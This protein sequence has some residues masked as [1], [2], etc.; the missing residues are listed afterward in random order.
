[1]N[2]LPLPLQDRTLRELLDLL[3]AGIHI[4]VGVTDDVH[5]L[6]TWALVCCAASL[7]LRIFRR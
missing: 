2:N 5:A 3:R 1:M 7:V 6:C 4:H